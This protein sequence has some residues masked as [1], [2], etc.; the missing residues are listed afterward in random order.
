MLF[1]NYNL[2]QQ[3]QPLP[4]L[5]FLHKRLSEIKVLKRADVNVMCSWIVTVP[6][7][8]SS[9]EYDTFFRECYKFLTDRYGKENVISA[10]NARNYSAAQL[11]NS[12]EKLKSYAET[13]I[14]T[15]TNIVTKVMGK[16][17]VIVSESDIV[18][19]Q[20][21]A[22]ETAAAI[23]EISSA[24]EKIKNIKKSADR[25]YE[26]SEQVLNTAQSKAAE[27]EKQAELSA[28]FSCQQNPSNFSAFLIQITILTLHL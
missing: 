11:R 23:E 21:A 1:L 22:A 4:Q 17:K 10:Y 7:N 13:N 3:D 24:S 18:S 16:D 26:K 9:S 12:G 28:S 5:E 8:V 15:S 6:E 20:K 14:R 2:A 27:I 25:N 19:T